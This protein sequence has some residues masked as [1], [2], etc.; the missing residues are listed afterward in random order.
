ML[1]YVYIYIYIYT[2]TH[3]YIYIYRSLSCGSM[4]CATSFW[5]SS[6]NPSSMQA[7][8]SRASNA[9]YPRLRQLSY[10][11]PHS[12]FGIARKDVGTVERNEYL[13]TSV[14]GPDMGN[15]WLEGAIASRAH[16]RS[17]HRHGLAFLTLI[18]QLILTPHPL[19]KQ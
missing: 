6:S 9:G 13:T 17:Q 3:T 11:P 10:C 16:C 15:L 8:R 12:G 1:S 5:S 14:Y 7:V 4:A 19:Q 2:H 18:K